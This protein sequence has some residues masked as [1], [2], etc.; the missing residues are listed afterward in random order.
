MRS[1]SIRLVRCLAAV[2]LTGLAMPGFAQSEPGPTDAKDP[3]FA[4]FDGFIAGLVQQ[5]K[6]SGVVLVAN[7]GHVLFEKAYGK[8]DEKGDDPNA[9]DTRFNLASG[10]PCCSG[11]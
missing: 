4:R 10:S 2:C 8:R 6:F 11:N 3:V 7:N 5:G 1:I 9:L